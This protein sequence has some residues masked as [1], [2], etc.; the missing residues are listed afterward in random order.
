VDFFVINVM[1]WKE[2]AIQVLNIRMMIDE[3]DTSVVCY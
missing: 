2:L 1:L 3:D